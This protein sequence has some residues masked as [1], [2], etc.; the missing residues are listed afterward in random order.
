MS[1]RRRG[2]LLVGLAF[3]LG[4]LAAA[5]LPTTLA[6][7]S[8]G[9]ALLSPFAALAWLDRTPALRRSLRLRARAGATV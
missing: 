2:L 9:V 1:R 4:A 6:A 8:V 7:V 3:V 5:L